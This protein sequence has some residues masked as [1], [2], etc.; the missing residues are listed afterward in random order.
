MGTVIAVSSG[1]G[2]VGKS[3][4]A[5]NLACALAASGL[6]VGLLDADIYG[7]SIPS[8]LGISAA[9]TMVEGLMMPPAAHGAAAVPGVPP[10]ALTGPAAAE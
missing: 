4:V 6:R 2:G 5:V 8:L 3:T 7:H 9:P 10:V 1:K